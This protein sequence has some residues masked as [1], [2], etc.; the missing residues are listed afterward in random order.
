MHPRCGIW[1]LA[2]RAL[3]AIFQTSYNPA[4]SA[5]AAADP[6]DRRDP[7][8]CRSYSPGALHDFAGNRTRLLV[9]A[10]SRHQ[11][12]PAGNLT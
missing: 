1:I 5:T 4:A 12:V 8:S 2:R 3:S 6:V 9:I 10:S 11:C 7:C